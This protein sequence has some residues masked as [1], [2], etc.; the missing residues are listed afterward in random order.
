MKILVSRRTIV[1]VACLLGIAAWAGRSEAAPM[2]FKVALTGPQETPP[3]ETAAT[4]TVDL[5]YDPSTM[6]VTWNVT[7]K[8]LSGPATMAHFHGPAKPGVAAAPT[9][10]MSTKGSTAPIEGPI[11][12]EATLTAEQAQQ[13]MAGDWYINVHTAANPKGEIRGQVVPPKS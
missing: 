6:V 8:G 2:A 7:C 9:I 11:K 4:G 10:W 5:T 3:V 12:G 1:L 13:L